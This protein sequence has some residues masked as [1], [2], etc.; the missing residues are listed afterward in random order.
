MLAS[1]HGVMARATGHEHR[2]LP[3]NQLICGCLDGSHTVIIE[4]DGGRVRI[5]SPIKGH[6]LPILGCDVI[7]R[8]ETFFLHS[9]NHTILWVS[10]VKCK[11][12]L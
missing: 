9:V 12:H 10:Y 5:Q 11:G 6:T 3:T 4:L 1:I 7:K 8:L 2:L